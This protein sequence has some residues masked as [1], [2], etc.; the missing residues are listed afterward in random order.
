MPRAAGD[1]NALGGTLEPQADGRLVFLDGLRAIAALM[2]ILPHA[3]GV[4][5]SVDSPGPIT[6]AVAACTVQGFSGTFFV[7]S[8]FVIARSMA[9][10]Q[11][12]ARACG[13]SF[14]RRCVRLLPPYWVG[15]AAVLAVAALRTTVSAQPPPLPE[16]PRIAA[17]LFGMQAVLGYEHLNPVFW[18][19]GYE[20]QMYAAFLLLLAGG[21]ACEVLASVPAGR[22]VAAVVLATFVASLAFPVGLV[23]SAAL[24][25][26]MLPCWHAFAAGAIAWLVTAGRLPRAVGI[27]CTGL[28]GAVVVCAPNTATLLI[29][30]T[31][32]ALFAGGL[33]GGMNRWLGFRPL[34][35]VGRVSYS[36][37]LLHVPVIALALGVQTRA[38]RGSEAAA[39]AIMVVL[40]GVSLTAA[41]MLNRAVERPCARAATYLKRFERTAEAVRPRTGSSDAVTRQPGRNKAGGR[42]HAADEPA[43]EA[44]PGDLAASH[45]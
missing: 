21:R 7:L 9:D 31:A 45:G 11:V 15:L 25:K 17:H 12:T 1:A 3:A 36:L 29:A 44:G 41:Y 42:G 19:L 40:Y 30:A 4:F 34:Q 37:Y 13:V 20:L 16:L 26:W 24:Y 14:L 39:C 43:A 2:V 33:S 8:G 18:T 23:S 32:T 27:A 22:V 10:R 35:F 28:L 38:F 5:T 6:R